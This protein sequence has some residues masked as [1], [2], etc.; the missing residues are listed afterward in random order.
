MANNC[1]QERVWQ[2]ARGSGPAVLLLQ[3]FSGVGKSRLA[4]ELVA[5]A[6]VPSVYIHVP[7]GTLGTQDLLFELAGS[8]EESGDYQMTAREDGDLLLGFE[9]ACKTPRLVII[10]DFQEL[11]AGPGLGPPAALMRSL[12]RICER[13]TRTRV[14][15]VS[16]QALPD[17]LWQ[18]AIDTVTFLPPAPSEAVDLLHQLLEDQGVPGSVPPDLTEDVVE[19]LGCNPRAMQV[20]ANCLR[21]EPLDDLIQAEARS[22]AERG[23]FTSSTLVE[24]LEGRLL[25]RTV[26]RLNSPSLVLLRSLAIY[27]IPFDRFGL[28]AF[29]EDLGEV[30]PLRDQ[31]VDNFLLEQHRGWYEM[32]PVARQLSILR[33]SADGRARQRGH[34]VAAAYYSRHF[35]A[36]DAATQLRHGKEFVEARY[37]LIASGQEAEFHE[38]AARLR[39]R[40]LASVRDLSGRLPEQAAQRR[41]LLAV[42]AAALSEEDAQHS[43]LRFTLARLLV[44][45]GAP[46]DL[47]AALN[48]SRRV[49]RGAALQEQWSLHLRLLGTIEGTQAVARAVPTAVRSM[50]AGSVPQIY[51]LA[52]K[53]LADLGDLPQAI[54]F[55]KQGLRLPLDD[56]VSVPMH[57]LHVGLL[58]RADNY[59][60][61]KSATI[62]ALSTADSASVAYNRFVETAVFPALA[63]QDAAHIR[64]IRDMLPPEC[65]LLRR[66]CEVL[67]LECQNR[68]QEAAALVDVVDVASYPALTYQAVF[69]WLVAGEAERAAAMV[70]TSVS[71]TNAASE[72]LTGLIALRSGRSDLARA[73]MERAAERSL[74]AS[75]RTDPNLWLRI[76]DQVPSAPRVYPSF[77]FPRLPSAL[78]SLASD[79]VRL[80][81]GPSVLSEEVLRS[82]A[83]AATNTSGLQSE[84]MRNPTV[85]VAITTQVS[86]NFGAITSTEDVIM[87]DKYEV[88]GAAGVVGR[89]AKAKDFD[90]T[91]GQPPSGQGGGG[92]EELAADLRRLRLALEASAQDPV[93][94]ADVERLHSAEIAAAGGDATEARTH[95]GGI[96]RWAL[97]AATAMGTT[98]AAAAIRDAAG[99]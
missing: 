1:P 55:V 23:Q 9:D 85:D 78:T 53:V 56:A 10:D 52:A 94:A 57:Q 54:E 13:G 16:A 61:A 89:N 79:L 26:A 21:A 99:F 24:R 37:H 2:W 22:W 34:E 66:L 17:G 28:E 75:E 71:R 82:P 3:G 73:A 30:A 12:A 7:H 81:D 42:L 63:R 49:V 33:L 95:L 84:S 50:A 97:G 6:T 18:D 70:N 31:L 72:W 48:Q 83:P 27:R 96:S 19:W 69:C 15:L 46:G 88:S 45:R 68:F 14:L 77:Y 20:L 36:L 92:A 41:E 98:L 5:A 11:L 80:E 86:P 47:R 51:T 59:P 29:R 76:W 90:V 40:L 65:K 60:A 93:E 38:I 4:R 62:E 64:V 43:T 8:L 74:T 35:R 91:S 44:D 67:I 25:S 58:L 87:G 32:Q 39:G